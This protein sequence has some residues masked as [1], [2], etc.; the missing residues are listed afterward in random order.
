MAGVWSKIKISLTGRRRGVGQRLFSLLLVA[1]CLGGIVFLSTISAQAV[2][3]LGLNRAN[4]VA[5][6]IQKNVSLSDVEKVLGKKNTIRLMKSY[7][8]ALAGATIEFEELPDYDTTIFFTIARAI[9]SDVEVSSFHIAGSDIVMDCLSP[10]GESADALFVALQ[11]SGYFSS[12]Y[13]SSPT[14]EE[15]LYFFEFHL[16]V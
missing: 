7:A 2:R 8:Q 10:N 4:T 14:K 12:V 15:D 11:E 5:A 13:Y 16:Q 9:P 6:S 3:E 1:V